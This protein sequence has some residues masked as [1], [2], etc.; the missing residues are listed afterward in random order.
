[1]ERLGEIDFGVAQERRR[2]QRA[3]E[4]LKAQCGD[5]PA[6]FARRWREVARGWSFADVNE[7]IG[8][9]NEWFPVERQLPMDPRTRDYV[10]IHGRSYRREL[11]DAAW[12]LREFPPEA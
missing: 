3:Y 6:G 8:Q 12:V 10:L 9:H 11:L 2:L 4:S 1:M 5:D 7:L